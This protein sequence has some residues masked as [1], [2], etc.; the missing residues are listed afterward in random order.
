MDRFPLAAVRNA[1]T[2]R[3]H[4]IYRK[5]NHVSCPEMYKCGLRHFLPPT[6]AQNDRRAPAPWVVDT[7]VSP[8]AIHS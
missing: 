7:R 4:R 5:F 3:T 1:F 8:V 6:P 2:T